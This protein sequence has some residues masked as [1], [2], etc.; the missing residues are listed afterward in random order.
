MT[1]QCKKRKE[2]EREEAR[3]ARGRFNKAQGR[4]QHWSESTGSSTPTQGHT[5]THTHSAYGCVSTRLQLR[6]LL[7]GAEAGDDGDAMRLQDRPQLRRRLLVGHSN[8]S[9]LLLGHHREH[10]AGGRHG[11]GGVEDRSSPFRQTGLDEGPCVLVCL[12]AAS[13]P[14]P[15]AHSGHLYDLH[16][17]LCHNTHTRAHPPLSR[18][19]HYRAHF[20]PG[21]GWGMAGSVP[22]SPS[23][24]PLLS[25]T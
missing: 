21:R 19:F 15:L 18:H 16:T 24:S 10:D 14:P 23:A 4:C 17:T 12:P 11:S 3:A 20:K 22:L 7:R 5:Q 8:S 6:A 9:K 13:L 1:E 2:G 25:N